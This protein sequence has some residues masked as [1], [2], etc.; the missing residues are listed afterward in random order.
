VVL[1]R[2]PSCVTRVWLFMD[3]RASGKGITDPRVRAAP[4]I[5]ARLVWV[6]YV[7]GKRRAILRPQAM[8]DAHRPFLP[9]E[10]LAATVINMTR[11]YSLEV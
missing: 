10:C 5:R 11:S 6:N 4:R 1:R 2:A 7:S 9:G 8:I 3:G